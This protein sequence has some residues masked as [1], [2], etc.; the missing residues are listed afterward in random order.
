MV[1]ES[2]GWVGGGHGT[3]DVIPQSVSIAEGLLV[4]CY[5]ADTGREEGGIG[6]GEG[7]RAGAVDEDALSRGGAQ[8]GK[9]FWGREEGLSGLGE[10][11]GPGAERD[12]GAKGF[13][14]ETTGST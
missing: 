3:E 2:T 9:D 6:A 4:R 7:E 11:G 12:G 8:V 10:L 1:D 5:D 14:E 13:D